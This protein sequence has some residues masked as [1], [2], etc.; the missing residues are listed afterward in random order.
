MPRA[1]NKHFSND[2]ELETISDDRIERI[3]KIDKEIISVKKDIK[4]IKKGESNADS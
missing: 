1:K 2:I 3:R 4:K